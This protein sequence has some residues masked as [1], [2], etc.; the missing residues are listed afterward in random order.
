MDI[1]GEFGRRRLTLPPP[2]PL[3]KANLKGRLEPH[4]IGDTNK[5]HD[6]QVAEEASQSRRRYTVPRRLR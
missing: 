4:Q 1:E 2:E 5:I 3:T 6:A